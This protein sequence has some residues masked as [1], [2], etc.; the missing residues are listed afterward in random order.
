M[1]FAENDKPVILVTG[2]SGQLGSELKE[3]SSAFSKYQFLFTT[4][5]DLAIEDKNA[6]NH[7][8][9]QHTI[10][11]CINCAAYTAVDKAEAEKEKAFLI[12]A[13]APGFL[14]SICKEHHAK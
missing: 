14:A 9:D 8:F 3:L 13:D 11:Y 10:N 2:A 4:K 6:V 1:A 5:N 12:N 7:F